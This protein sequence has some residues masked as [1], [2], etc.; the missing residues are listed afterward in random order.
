MNCVKIFMTHELTALLEREHVRQVLATYCLRL[1]ECD[2]AGVI[3]CFAEDAVADYGP[4]RGGLVVELPEDS[5]HFGA[6]IINLAR[7]ILNS[8]GRRRAR[9]VTSPRGMND[10]RANEKSSVCDI[11]IR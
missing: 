9:L 1:D 10:I 3:A 8:L 7:S 2:F 4:G 5:R 11:S 6:R